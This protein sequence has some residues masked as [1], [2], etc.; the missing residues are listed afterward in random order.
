MSSPV[1]YSYLW[2][3]PDDK[4]HIF[5]ASLLISYC[6]FNLIV[7]SHFNYILYR[8]F[9]NRKGSSD[10]SVVSWTKNEYGLSVHFL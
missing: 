3:F 5:A 8:F 1:R 7:E 9:L 6:N 2:S 10:E 4:A